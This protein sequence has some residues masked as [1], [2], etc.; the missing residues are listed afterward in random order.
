MRYLLCAGARVIYFTEFCM[1]GLNWVFFPFGEIL[2]WI[3]QWTPH[4]TAIE[5]NGLN[6]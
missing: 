1:Q 4:L 5:C 3:C 2:T 6:Y